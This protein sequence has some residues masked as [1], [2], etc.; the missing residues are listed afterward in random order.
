MIIINIKLIGNLKSI[1]YN[2]KDQEMEKFI[3]LLLYLVLIVVI[4]EWYYWYR[5]IPN[6]RRAAQNGYK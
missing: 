3:G 5:Y 6:L 2:I 4:E 1:W